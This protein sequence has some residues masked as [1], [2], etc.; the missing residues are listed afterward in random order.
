[1]FMISVRVPYARLPATVI[2]SVVTASRSEAVTES[3]DPDTDNCGST[4]AR[5]SPDGQRDSE[6]PHPKQKAQLKPRFQTS[7]I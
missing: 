2:L 7:A 3:K 4:T 6:S 1:M 5:Q